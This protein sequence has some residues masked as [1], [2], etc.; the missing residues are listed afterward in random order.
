MPENEQ[1]N[2]F[3]NPEG[4]LAV[5]VYQ[6]EK[7]LVVQS[8][9]AG[10]QSHDLDVFISGDLLTIRGRRLP[11]SNVPKDQYFWRECFWGSFSRSIILPVEVEQGHIDASIKN[12]V[13]TVRLPKKKR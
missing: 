2:W 8:A 4:E 11:P 1:K 9:I 5:D 12:G 13:L 3:N 10:A 7:D 6:T